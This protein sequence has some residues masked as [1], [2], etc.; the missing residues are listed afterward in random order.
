MGP[1]ACLR[2]LWGSSGP[3]LT[4]TGLGSSPSAQTELS[5]RP[6]SRP[7]GA[8]DSSFRWDEDPR[9][10]AQAMSERLLLKGFWVK[11]AGL[12]AGNRIS[13]RLPANDVQE[14]RLTCVLRRRLDGPRLQDK[15]TLVGPLQLLRL[16]VSIPASS[17]RLQ[18]PHM[19]HVDAEGELMTWWSST[20]SHPAVV[21]HSRKLVGL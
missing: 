10:N 17:L 11:S 13:G 2:F 16:R 3:S 21:S 19:A 8:S 20:T 12:R 9:Q 1:V 14:K 18:P 15:L 7:R 6:N 5:G 4:M